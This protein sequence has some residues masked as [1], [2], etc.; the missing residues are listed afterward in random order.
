MGNLGQKGGQGISDDSSEV[1][2]LLPTIIVYVSSGQDIS[3]M[4]HP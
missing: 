2:L 4:T 1:A 3:P